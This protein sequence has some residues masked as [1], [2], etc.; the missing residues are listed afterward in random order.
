MFG[1]QPGYSPGS[2]DQPR[3]SCTLCGGE[4]GGVPNWGARDPVRPTETVA[5]VC[6]GCYRSAWDGN[7][8][9][10]EAEARRHVALEVKPEEAGD[11]KDADGRTADAVAGAGGVG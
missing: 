11:T 3:E 9:A 4:V 6:A 10:L 7:A 2:D 1:P 8:A 5:L